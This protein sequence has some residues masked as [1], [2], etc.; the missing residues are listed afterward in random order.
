MANNLLNN[1]LQQLEDEEK[2]LDQLE[3]VV[4][5]GQ[6][7]LDRAKSARAEC[8]RR[9][10]TLEASIR[11]YGQISISDHAVLRYLERK[12][13]L[14]LD[15][16]REKILPVKEIERIYNAGD[17]KYD[18]GDHRVVVVNNTVVTVIKL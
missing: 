1:Y 18:I 15:Q 6:V 4:K 16:I 11:N 8:K 3:E 13:N 5:T 12:I 10:S 7:E 9:I 2:Q 14:D 17:G